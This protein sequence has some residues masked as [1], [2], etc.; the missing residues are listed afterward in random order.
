MGKTV[1]EMMGTVK[2]V[3]AKGANRVGFNPCRSSSGGGTGGDILFVLV[4]SLL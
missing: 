4:L 1:T 2:T 3:A